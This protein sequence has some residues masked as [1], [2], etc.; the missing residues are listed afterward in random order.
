V[1]VGW[2]FEDR[3]FYIGSW[4][5]KLILAPLGITISQGTSF[6]FLL[7][8]RK[9]IVLAAILYSGSRPI[10]FSLHKCAPFH[11]FWWLNATE[12]LPRNCEWIFIRQQ[13]LGIFM[14]KQSVR[15]TNWGEMAIFLRGIYILSST[16]CIHIDVIS[17]L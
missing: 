10:L 12:F 3:T 11:I 7:F 2:R 16:T 13:V 4:R 9:N 14:D 8:W 6:S 17:L 5:A 1:E 15:A